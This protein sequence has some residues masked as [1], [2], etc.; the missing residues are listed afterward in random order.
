[1]LTEQNHAGEHILSE[2]S[3]ERSRDSVLIKSGLILVAGTLLGQITAEPGVYA[4]YADGNADGTEVASKVLF[5]PIDTSVDGTNED[6]LAAVNSRDCELSS[7]RLT[8]A[9]A[10]G[11]ADLA[12]LG[13][14]VRT[15]L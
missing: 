10:N 5:G 7:G 6:T 3:G 13:M 14:I 8:G 12:A 2:A 4:E 9:D 15:S 11:I 1:M